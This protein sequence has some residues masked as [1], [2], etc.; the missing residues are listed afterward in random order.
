[1]FDFREGESTKK[2]SFSEDGELGIGTKAVVKVSIYGEGSRAS[3]RLEKL[4][5]T[6]LVEYDGESSGSVVNKDAF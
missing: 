1:M 5:V 6:D 3:I 4:A 2:W